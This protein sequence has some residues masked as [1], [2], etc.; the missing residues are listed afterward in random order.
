MSN[1]IRIINMII[2]NSGKS[3]HGADDTLPLLIYVMLKA[4]APRL[5]S[6][7]SYIKYFRYLPRREIRDP[8]EFRYALTTYKIALNF[9]L[10]LSPE[11]LYMIPGETASPSEHQTI[12]KETQTE[13]QEDLLDL[14]ECYNGPLTVEHLQA[15]PHD[16][17]ALIAHYTQLTNH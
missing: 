3:M 9:I 5:Y 14:T 16:L 12:D 10:M 11:K 13:P 17:E 2:K 6:T 15:N 4:K 1:T 8:V 7:Y